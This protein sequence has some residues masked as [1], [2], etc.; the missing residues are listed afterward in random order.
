VLRIDTSLTKSYVED[1]RSQCSRMGPTKSS[2]AEVRKT[3]VVGGYLGMKSAVIVVIV[4]IAG[5]I[6]HE[7]GLRCLNVSLVSRGNN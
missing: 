1:F 6:R 3:L 5:F 2:V 4:V 7:S